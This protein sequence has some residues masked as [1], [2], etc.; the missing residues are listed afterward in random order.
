MDQLQTILDG[1]LDLGEKIKELT[2]ALDRGDFPPNDM[3]A[4]AVVMTRENQK[5]LT[6][7]SGLVAKILGG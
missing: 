6:N 4:I 5:L 7:L 2:E 1:D 3:I